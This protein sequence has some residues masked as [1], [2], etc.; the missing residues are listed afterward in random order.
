[1][2]NV[3]WVPAAPETVGSFSAACYYFARE[4]RTSVNVP[5]GLVNASYGGARLRT[6]MSEA[7]LRPLGIDSDALDILNVYRSDPA[8]ATRRWGALWESAWE[9]ARPGDGRPWLPSFDD[10][11]WKTA[12]AALG[13]W[14]LWS[15]TDPDAGFIGQ[16]WMRTTVTLT[17]IQAARDDASLDLGSVN[18]E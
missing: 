3:R 8:A 16:V 6:F 5:I 2:R 14:A 18:Q 10:A 1:A 11:S 17:A 4:L 9:T 7:T 12:P 13:P 15:G